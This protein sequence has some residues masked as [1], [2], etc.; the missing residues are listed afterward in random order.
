[1]KEKS[2]K[3]MNLIFLLLAVNS[4]AAAGE[5]KEDNEIII[6]G[7]EYK[8]SDKNKS[9]KEKKSSDTYNENEM[10]IP[11]M[12]D[13][14]YD[15]DI[16]DEETEELP[17][18]FSDSADSADSAVVKENIPVVKENS[19]VRAEKEVLGNLVNYETAGN[20]TATDNTG[21]WAID[22]N[23]NVVNKYIIESYYTDNNAN[24][25]SAEISQNANF[26]NDG[27]VSGN[28]GGVSL[29]SGAAMKN[30]GTID[31]TGNY[32]VYLEGSET[33]LNNNSTGKIVNEGDYGVY[34]N[35]G[36]KAEN[37]GLVA[38]SGKFGIYVNNGETVNNGVVKNEDNF[39]IY[40]AGS[41]AVSKNKGTISNTGNYGLFAGEGAKAENSAGGIIENT[42]DYGIY[43]N[44]EESTAENHG[45][46]RNGKAYG[47][48][49]KNG[50][51][52]VNAINGEISNETDYG[53]YADG[54]GTAAQNDGTVKN[55]GNRGVQA[56]SGGEG[57]NSETGIIQNTGNSG[58][59][60]DSGSSI[61]NS[62]VIENGGS[63]GMYVTGKGTGVN[64]GTIANKKEY[65]ITVSEADSLAINDET[66]VI[67]NN[68]RFG[69]NVENSATGINKGVIA[70]NGILGMH[71]KNKAQG[72]NYGT[73]SNTQDYGA[74]VIGGDTKF[75]NEETGV[76]YNTGKSGIYVIGTG[77]A[78]NKG[79]VKNSQDYGVYVEEAGSSFVNEKSGTIANNGR[80]GIY[81]S[82]GEGENNGI[83]M[84]AGDAGIYITDS[85]TVRNRG[86]ILNDGIQGIY[87]KNKGKGYNS[88]TVKNTQN[89]GVYVA[90]TDSYFSNESAG[91]IEN[92]GA[93]GIHTTSGANAEN[94]GL[95][96]NT[97]EYGMY[98]SD[99]SIV[100]NKETGVIANKGSTG[101][102]AT[103][104][105][106][107]VN[108]GII[109]NAGERGMHL[110]Q[111]SRGINT[112][113][114]KNTGDSGV[115]VVE[116][117]KVINYGIIENA[118]DYGILLDTG[119]IATNNGT[120]RNS[121]NYGIYSRQSE[122]ATIAANHGTIHLTGDNKT[123]VYVNNTTFINNGIIRIDGK[124]AT[125][126]K[127]ENN[128]IVKIGQNSQIILDGNDP[129]TQANTDYE[130]ITSSGTANS[131]SGGKAYDLDSTSTLVN[132]G[133]ILT[134]GNF[135]VEK[136]GKFVLDTLTGEI[137]ASSLNLEGDIYVNA[138]GLLDSS[139]NS[140]ILENIKVDSVTGTGNIMSDSYLFTASMEN[141]NDN[142]SMIMNRKDFNDVF[143]GDLGKVLENNY[144]GSENIDEQ[145]SLYNS[146]K[147]NV[148]SEASAKTAQ[149]EITGES[150]LSNLS[151]QQLQQNKMLEDGIFE[152]LDK[153]SDVNQGFYLNFLGGKT[154]ADTKEN[155]IGYDSDSYGFTAGVMKKTGENTSIGGFVGYLNSDTDYKDN[156]KSNQ[157]TDTW[158][159][160]GAVEQVITDKLVW[161]STIGY[162]ISNTDTARKITYDSTNREVK[163][164]FDSWS[165][166]AKT[167]LKYTY[168]ITDR[169]NLRPM[170]GI[171]LD[172]LSQ[173]GYTESGAGYNMDVKSAE[174][175]S[176]R[177]EIGLESEITVFKNDT[178]NI[179]VIPSARY[180]YETGN[181]YKDR[182]IVL[183]GFNDAVSVESR[184][185]GRNDLNLGLGIEYGFK[186]KIKLYGEYNKGVSDDNDNQVIKAGFKI[187][188]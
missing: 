23:T 169:I 12:P 22:N 45:I 29:H 140:Y 41:A 175:F 87:V 158:T 48:I 105:S 5:V 171:S 57:I 138:E 111:N 98:A 142:Y 49:A 149:E 4:I 47:M 147:K 144:S 38:N 125:G 93:Y 68:G 155:A 14:L 177:P 2:K 95:V 146:L 101:M 104:Y 143:S 185:T 118:G 26:V 61:L 151:Y 103:A 28:K 106:D 20:I 89:Y 176:V 132:A 80:Y 188:W 128:S 90:G 64:T 44:G 27:I 184:E 53:M 72:Y 161:T 31:N 39:G 97:R 56:S 113:T 109:E 18:D 3:I 115:V 160:K 180:S 154:E 13:D 130:D 34:L 181:P 127:A 1:M 67:S 174:A 52:V 150:I 66:G 30:N 117:S 121:G 166:N 11:D 59:Y 124:N 63:Y 167:Q 73:I 162:N 133:T 134:S 76:I 96:K 32:G 84:N 122:T 65:G 108:M 8:M 168:D 165:L 19:V 25:F 110:R 157:N 9:K 148:A 141:E 156:G 35:V 83:V 79:L 42:G 88:G 164:N 81:I 71:V 15:D 119:G 116:S 51:K 60:S 120:I 62:G 82:E 129:I 99:S 153:K 126:I 152:L 21:L 187:L 78:E 139:E 163:G 107:A 43:T 173:D 86:V 77:R 54:T 33:R 102:L 170:A 74:Y 100:T 6:L 7:T 75:I 55:N 85:G 183:A 10:R 94:Y 40:T 137:E 172:Y 36:T 112:G 70:N 37:N 135:T 92:T 114:I 24:N 50:G 159:I 145:N 179:K 46:I 69:M 136:E 131:N 17:D 58:M 178:S 91:R 123:G 16:N 186:D 182:D